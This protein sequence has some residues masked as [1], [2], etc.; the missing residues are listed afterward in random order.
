[1]VIH[2]TLDRSP[3]TAEERRRALEAMDAADRLRQEI[4]AR[5]G[6]QPFTPESWE[7][8]NASRD[9]RSRNLA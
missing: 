4:L 2:E 3:L 9:E 7:L 1:M 6:G 5:R 8:L